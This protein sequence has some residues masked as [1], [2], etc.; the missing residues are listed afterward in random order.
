MLVGWGVGRRACLDMWARLICATWVI[1]LAGEGWGHLLRPR[2]RALCVTTPPTIWRVLRG[3]MPSK[4]WVGV[5]GD[6][7]VVVTGRPG[8]DSESDL[9]ME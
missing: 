3:W 2:E 5:L 1:R 8:E 6:G 7:W 9:N 4:P